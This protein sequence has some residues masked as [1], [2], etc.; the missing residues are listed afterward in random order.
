MKPTDILYNIVLNHMAE[1]KKLTQLISLVI[2]NTLVE[3]IPID[4]TKLIGDW[5]EVKPGDR[6]TIT[7]T[8]PF[9]IEYGFIFTLP[10]LCDSMLD[11]AIVQIPSMSEDPESQCWLPLAYLTAFAASVELEIEL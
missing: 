6:V 11:S 7:Y 1:N 9:R 5:D 8:D 4:T 3:P 10:G 2:N